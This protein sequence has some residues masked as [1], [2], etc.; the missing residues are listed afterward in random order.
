MTLTC[1]RV[2]KIKIKLTSPCTGDLEN[3]FIGW[4]ALRERLQ[5]D[6]VDKYLTAGLLIEDALN[7]RMHYTIL[8]SF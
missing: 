8:S 1:N 2:K 6:Q 5:S 7:I 3:H 4:Q